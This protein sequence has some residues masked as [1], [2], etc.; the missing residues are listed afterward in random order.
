MFQGTRI[1][2]RVLCAMALTA[3]LSIPALA[4]DIMV[5][6]DGQPVPFAGQRPVLR[7]GTVLVPLR[8]VFE[9]L[10]ASVNYDAP[11]KRVIAV[12]GDTTVALTIGSDTAYINGD[13]HRLLLPADVMAGSTMV[14]LRFVSEALG[15]DVEWQ[16][17]TQT[18]QIVTGATNAG[19]LPPAAGAGDI[20]GRVT[21]LFPQRNP[22][23]ITLMYN[24]QNLQIPLASQVV[25]LVN[26]PDGRSVRMHLS[27]IRVGD[28]VTV[29]R[30][31]DG[32]GTVVSSSYGEA[33][34]TFKSARAL[35]NGGYLITLDDGST[36]ELAADSPITMA[37]QPLSVSDIHP[38]DHV[39]VR[40][41][42]QT[43]VAY[44]MA[45]VTGENPTPTPPA[46]VRIASFTFSPTGF[47]KLGETI[48]ATMTGTPGGNASFEIPGVNGAEAIPMTERD[49]GTYKGVFQIPEG[50]SVRHASVLGTLTV[51]DVSAPTIQAAGNVTIDSIGPTISGMTP[52]EGTAVNDGRPLIYATFG[53]PTSGVENVIVKVDGTDVTSASTITPSFFSYRPDEPLADGPHTVVVRVSDQ[54]GNSTE[55]IVR[56]R[57]RG[58][59]DVVRSVSVSPAGPYE[60]GDVISVTLTASPG[61]TATCNIGDVITGFALSETE[62]GRYEGSYKVRR[63]DSVQKGPLTVRFRS[64]DGA[65]VT[66]TAPDS[67]TINAGAPGAP[68]VVSPIEG[69]VVDTPVVISGTAKPHA[70]VTV[71][72]T[73]SGKMLVLPVSG[74]VATV[75]VRAD[76]DGRWAT[77]PIQLARPLGVTRIQYQA[78]AATLDPSGQRSDEATVSF[79]GR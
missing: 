66:A 58:S 35:A 10:G 9:R 65:E 77:E 25:V 28:Q 57:V 31:A 1:I 4:A 54:A 64:R 61:G 6:V 50:V 34:G 14:P 51:G 67:I 37:D 20:T 33:T 74:T 8:G 16:G 60:I 49:A 41:N 3:L 55:Q 79:R 18:V 73:Y 70:T 68:V 17:S 76:R 5:T 39:V 7:A 2:Y 24:G 12:K 69:A 42:P 27:D 13:A 38:G 78:T 26:L 46:A 45:V 72:V 23:T 32:T 52:E 36:F 21:G 22:P 43:K 75:E 29:T 47:L 19:N 15:A 71:E 62:R 30:S 44:G 56:F 48:R 11:T 63:G 40:T 53:D 59:S